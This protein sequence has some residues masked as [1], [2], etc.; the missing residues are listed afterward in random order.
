MVE[1]TKT[2]DQTAAT[3]IDV[4]SGVK[5]FRLN[6]YSIPDRIVFSHNNV[7]YAI[8]RTGVSVKMKMKKSGLPLSFAIPARTFEGIAAKAVELSDGTQQVTLEL[9]HQDPALCIPV[10]VSDNL[11]DI[12]ADWHSWSRLM[13]LPMLMI[14]ADN[15]AHPVR[16]EL[17]MVMIE[18]P[19]E[20]RKRISTIK[21]RPWFLRRRKVGIVGEVQKI[22][23]AE[24][25]ARA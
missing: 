17:G 22:T 13:K 9:H 2:A 8:D 12:A 5:H 10:L 3:N 14:G 21:Q 4:N 18:D 7:K 16:E 11:D 6:P 20:R 1:M 19:I 15:M 23:A 24:I 25:I